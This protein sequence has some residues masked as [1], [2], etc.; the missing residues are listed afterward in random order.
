MNPPIAKRLPVTQSVH[1]HTLV[2]E[3]DWLRAENWQE[4]VDEPALLPDDIKSYLKAEND[5]FDQAMLNTKEL[6]TTLLAE[7][8]GRIEADD[9][10][11]PDHDG[12]WS[13]IERFQ[14]D[15]EH[16]T[17]WRYPR[18]SDKEGPV[19][20]SGDDEFSR[21]EQS[22]SLL[23]DFNK[24]SEGH[25]YFDAGDVDY[26]PCHRYLAW[27]ADTSGAERYTLKIRNLATGIDEDVIEDIESVTWGDSQFLFYTRLDSDH[28][29]SLLYRHRLGTNAENDV[30]VYR[31]T[32]A[33]F[34]CSVWTSLSGK[35]VFF[36]SDMSDQSEV[37]YI[38][39]D[40]MTAE[41]TVIQKRQ[42]GLE[43]SVE[44]QGERFLIKTNV[45]SCADFK[46][47]ECPCETPS[48]EHWQDWLPY[49]AGRMVL[50]HYAYKD[51]VMWLERENALPR[52]CYR[53]NAETDVESLEFSGEAYA[54][55]LDTLLEFDECSFQFSYESPATPTQTYSF[56]MVSQDRRLLKEER[57]PSGH[58]PED[59]IVQRRLVETADNQAVP[60]TIVFH[61]NTALDGTAPCWL[62]GYGSYGSSY[63]ASF[64][65]SR[66][67]LLDRGFVFAIA[68]VR[69]GQEKGRAWYE[70]ARFG[71]KPNSMNDFVDCGHFLVEHSYTDSGRIVASGGSAGGLLV[72]AAINQDNHPF[73][74]AVADVPFVDVLNTMLDDSLPLTP[75][76]WS[77]WGNPKDSKE[78]FDDILGYSPYEN[79]SAK[80]YPHML[81]TAGVSDPRVTYWE[82][83][84]WVARHR[85][86]R[87]DNQLLLLKTNMH[88]GHF[89][90]TGRYASLADVVIEQAFAIK[91]LGLLP[92]TNSTEK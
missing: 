63:P 23:I 25:A 82:P 26:S 36:S 17:Y 74:A 53:H 75:G 59:Y 14:G 89:G 54:L 21:H 7:M 16:S 39:V 9:T 58:N 10:S 62:T 52:I 32:D 6:Q 46:L 1:G 88:S 15:D 33:R 67:S 27:S 5:W 68:H 40:D 31:E 69:G 64:S 83:A 35:Y 42:E 47:V 65:S 87:N 34:Y 92:V 84:K 11:L 20:S 86:L 81:V 61:K 8:K 66:L 77:Q 78:A 24:E 55:G 50:D 3:Y 85:H 79:V 28:R 37:W 70:A 43:Y 76:E 13:Y 2:D 48:M 57:I 49:Q 22:A 51:W 18:V 38:P 44:H 71:G 80:V 72:G 60:L 12:P 45:D 29:P 41:P 73:G 19:V 91:A 90:E 4:C 56:D 30:L